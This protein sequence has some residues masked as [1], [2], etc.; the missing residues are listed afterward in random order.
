MKQGTVFQKPEDL[1]GNGVLYCELD[2]ENN[3]F[4]QNVV[5]PPTHITATDGLEKWK[6]KSVVERFSCVPK[7]FVSVLKNFSFPNFWLGA[8]K[9]LVG[10]KF[11]YYC[12]ET[13]Q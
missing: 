11:G 9:C 13:C 1:D 12:K 2:T 8:V 6:V 4:E 7:V 10:I 3:L 5:E